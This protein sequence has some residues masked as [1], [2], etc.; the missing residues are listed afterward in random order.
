MGKR[1]DDGMTINI[2]TEKC[3]KLIYECRFTDDGMEAVRN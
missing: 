2:E 3:G 1:S